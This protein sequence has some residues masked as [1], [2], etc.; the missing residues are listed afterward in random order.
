M[1]F[2]KVPLI[3]ITATKSLKNMIG[4]NLKKKDISTCK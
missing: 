3:G 4:V 2:T 1:A